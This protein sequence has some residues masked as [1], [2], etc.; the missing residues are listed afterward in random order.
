MFWVTYHGDNSMKKSTVPKPM[1]PSPFGGHQTRVM[2]RILLSLFGSGELWAIMLRQAIL[3][4][5]CSMGRRSESI[6]LL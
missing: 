2:S 1:C 6:G 4:E 5:T 3:L